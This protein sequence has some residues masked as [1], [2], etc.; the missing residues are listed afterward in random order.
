MH[1]L[2]YSYLSS[3]V[4]KGFDSYKYSS[5]D[6]SPFAN[7]VMH[8]FWNWL[9]QFLPRKLAPNL[10]TLSGFLC[11]VFN[12]LL[13][14]YYDPDLHA[15]SVDF[16]DHP[17]VPRV[18]W[19]LS[20]MLNFASHTLDGMDGKQARRTGTSSPV[21]ELFD[22]GLDSWATLFFPMCV[23]SVFGRGQYGGQPVRVY[24]L[25]LAIMG[26]FVLS[27]WE[28]YVTGMF[29]L[30]WAYDLSQIG[31]VAVYAFTFASGDRYWQT[32]AIGDRTYTDLVILSCYIGFW[33]L[34]VP[35]TLLNVYSAFAKQTVRHRRLSAA[36]EPLL[37]P[38]VLLAFSALW[39]H[40][41][42]NQ[43]IFAYPRL[44]YA[45]FGTVFSNIACR[46]IVSQMSSTRCQAFNL[47][48]G[49]Y[50]AVSVAICLLRPSMQAEFAVLLS[51][52]ALSVLMHVHY[53]CN[54]VNQMLD[55]FKLRAFVIASPSREKSN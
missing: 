4:I 35:L 22:H 23:Y 49:I 14:A 47:M 17:Q 33:I 36:M 15:S 48:T 6:T 13:L 9:V 31:L 43:I 24:Y 38:A 44:F 8:P 7:Y 42:P 55:H 21:G 30:P 53:G 3:D 37:S 26:Q 34:C 25:Y 52:L 45:A 46:L 20:A 18:L 40:C 51:L 10:M 1:L 12:C 11:L 39:V 2:C 28:K 29:F 41:S 27:H 16:P 50:S 54:V 5:Q 19:L 32:Y